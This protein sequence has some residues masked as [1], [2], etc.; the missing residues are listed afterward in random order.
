M[1][2]I[3]FY[4]IGWGAWVIATFFMAKTKSRMYTAIVILVTIAL[5]ITELRIFGYEVSAAFVFSV[6]I[7]YFLL[8]KL[9]F[10]KL[11]Y[12]FITCIILAF[13]YVSFSL[14]A[15]YDPVWVIFD[16]SLML[17]TTLV[18]LTLFLVKDQ[19]LRVVS[20]TVGAIQ[21]EVVYSVVLHSIY[22][23]KPIGTLAFFD[24]LAIAIIFTY[25]WYSFELFV[26]YT[27]SYF[28]KK[29]RKKDVVING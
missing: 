16:Y 2:G 22:Y 21:G 18:V 7:G 23:Q 13:A 19:Y 24:M 9:A 6:I 4:W 1:D 27:D 12:Y 15:L 20:L 26:E 3:Y 5:S 8:S 11:L 25:L 29:Q 10:L 14:F 28:K 17:A